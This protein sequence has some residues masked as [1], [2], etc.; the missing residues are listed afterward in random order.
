MRGKGKNFLRAAAAAWLALLL[1]AGTACAEAPD[2]EGSEEAPSLYDDPQDV[3]ECGDYEYIVLPD[4]TAGIVQF[5]GPGDSIAVPAELDGL[6]VTEIGDSA[7][8]DNR[9]MVTLSVPEGV[10]AIRDYAFSGCIRL[11][12][13]SL[14]DS[15][16]VL[17]AGA[18]QK[19]SGLEELVLPDGI[20]EID[21]ATFT[22]SG[23]KRITLPAGLRRI[24]AQAFQQSE[25][26]TVTIPEGTEEILNLAFCDCAELKE[27]ILPDS[28]ASVE[29]NPFMDCPLISFTF[30]ESHPYLELKDGVLFSRPD[31][32]L[33]C[34]PDS[35]EADTYAIPE[36]TRIIGY[37]ALRHIREITIP[38]GV[39]AIDD[40]AFGSSSLTSV[41]IPDSVAVLGNGVFRL[42]AQL[43]GVTLPAGITQIPGMTFDGC[44]ALASLTVPE[45]VT[46]IGPN[47]F[48]YC[49]G[50]KEAVLPESLEEIGKYA[51]CGCRSLESLSLPAQVAQ[52]GPYAFKDCGA[53]TVSV[54]KGSF[55]HTWCMENRVP[56]LYE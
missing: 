54:V 41:T 39:T 38:D 42:C 5:Y 48:R 40:Y 28:L 34:Y 3:R 52:I 35:L 45:G 4:G 55:A 19:T 17:G 18:F 53:L 30:S 20:T 21:G 25:L 2:S 16:A 22:F 46:S 13:V 44:S 56:W 31:A 11:S 47:A 6:P 15:L 36:G 23:L 1:L 8:E 26:E 37:G 24:G 9:G 12:S 27:V 33:I 10:R 50:L 7:F 32:R 51:F 14:P 43:T 49:R 29:G